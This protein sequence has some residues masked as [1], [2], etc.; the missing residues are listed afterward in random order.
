MHTTRMNVHTLYSE[1][2]E[3]QRLPSVDA[4]VD[5]TIAG[6]TR[7]LAFVA[8]LYAHLGQKVNL[9]A[10]FRDEHV[11]PVLLKH[12]PSVWNDDIAGVVVIARDILAEHADLRV[13]L[14][15]ATINTDA[16]PPPVA[17]A[18]PGTPS[19][20]ALTAQLNRLSL[21]K[22][23]DEYIVERSKRNVSTMAE[24]TGSRVPMD[25]VR[26]CAST[27]VVRDDDVESPWTP[28]FVLLREQSDR[29]VHHVNASVLAFLKELTSDF[30]DDNGLPRT[31]TWQFSHE[32]TYA[33]HLQKFKDAAARLCPEHP[34][35]FIVFACAMGIPIHELM[36]TRD[37]LTSWKSSR[38]KLFTQENII[39]LLL[40]PR[41]ESEASDVEANRLTRKYMEHVSDFQSVDVTDD[42]D[43]LFYKKFYAYPAAD[44][45]QHL[46]ERVHKHTH[47]WF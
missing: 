22:T 46:A 6:K 39:K 27:L 19:V 47:D 45:I 8:A 5:L 28:Q 12:I 40:R 43:L 17:S 11:A 25:W 26:Q 15:I 31:L 42:I 1:W 24:M 9:T 32:S 2:K 30:T 3:Y 29:H 7:D 16:L 4:V 36:K 10:S 38:F 21:A 20:D 23:A 13:F 33:I 14:G 34:Y 41:F 18:A 35:A 44:E 37:I